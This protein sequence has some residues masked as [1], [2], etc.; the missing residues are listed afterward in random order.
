MSGPSKYDDEARALVV[1]LDAEAVVLVVVGGVKG[2]GACPAIRMSG[3][4]ERD[5]IIRGAIVAGLRSMADGMEA[6]T[7][8]GSADWK[9]GVS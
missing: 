3:D 4:P 1:A 7:E 5:R 8:M 9:R 6:G 2:T